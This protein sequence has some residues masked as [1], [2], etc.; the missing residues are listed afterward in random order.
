[1]GTEERKRKR[2]TYHLAQ[3]LHQV[4]VRLPVKKTGLIDITPQGGTDT[5]K[6][7]TSILGYI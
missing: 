7:T 5:S 2:G 4:A 1:M 3:H 6:S